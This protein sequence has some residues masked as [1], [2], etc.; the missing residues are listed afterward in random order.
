MKSLAM[1][2][3]LVGSMFM[4]AGCMTPAYS[5]AERG[6]MIANNIAFEYTTINDDIDNIFLLRPKTRLTMWHVR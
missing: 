6:A 3:L 4:S 1:L 2:V 5:G